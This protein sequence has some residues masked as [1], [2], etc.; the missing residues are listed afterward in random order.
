MQ[1]IL[2]FRTKKKTKKKNLGEH[3]PRLCPTSI[4]THLFAPLVTISSDS[5][6]VP[7]AIQQIHNKP[8]TYANSHTQTSQ[9]Q[10]TLTVG[11]SILPPSL[12]ELVGLKENS[13]SPPP[14][15]LKST[16]NDWWSGTSYT[17][18]IYI[19]MHVRENTA[20]KKTL[21]SLSLTHKSPDSRYLI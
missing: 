5:L 21:K 6:K 19:C 12:V 20:S 3:T 1:A 9:T 4:Y 17:T 14:K 16:V 18:C 10:H 2:G 11:T 15:Y 8:T 7:G 13:T